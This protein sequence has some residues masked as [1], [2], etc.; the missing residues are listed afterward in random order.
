MLKSASTT[1]I[2]LGVLAV[3]I[4][5]VAIARPGVGAVTLALLFGLFSLMYG[6][7]Q[8][9]AGIHV[10]QVAKG[11]HSLAAELHHAA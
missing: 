3:I 11:A 4:G 5:I 8:I 6:F 1:L 9:N 10:R 2:L 7:A